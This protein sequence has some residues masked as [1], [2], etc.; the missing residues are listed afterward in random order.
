MANNDTVELTIDGRAG[1]GPD[2]FA[3]SNYLR[4]Y[5]D[6]GRDIIRDTD[7]LLTEV[8]EL[9]KLYCAANG[10]RESHGETLARYVHGAKPALLVRNTFTSPSIVWLAHGAKPAQLVF[11]SLASRSSVMLSTW[12]FSIIC[13]NTDSVGHPEAAASTP[14]SSPKGAAKVIDH[15][16]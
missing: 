5:R 10:V 12:S 7:A 9:L 4:E 2:T 3:T 1:P 6:A 8:R 14:S 15:R 13:R 11:A 16:P